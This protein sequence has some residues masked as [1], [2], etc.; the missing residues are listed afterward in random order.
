MQAE[1]DMSNVSR[2]IFDAIELPCTWCGSE[3]PLPPGEF[4]GVCISCGTVMFRPAAK[5]ARRFAQA[6]RSDVRGG[7][8]IP[9]P[10]V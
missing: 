9:A 5:V 3:V 8:W 7:A 4:S 1:M 6:Q 10:A 2:L